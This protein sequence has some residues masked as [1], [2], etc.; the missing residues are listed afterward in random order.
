MG[1]GD[2]CDL[3]P[4]LG[5]QRWAVREVGDGRRAGRFPCDYTS[6][7]GRGSSEA[8]AVRIYKQ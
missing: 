6:S 5:K 4:R 2:G 1:P 8:V 3:R 7:D